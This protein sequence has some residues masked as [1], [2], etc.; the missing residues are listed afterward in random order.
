[1]KFFEQEHVFK[2]DWD[3]VTSAFWRKYPNSLQ[4]HVERVDMIQ[5][6]FD[7]INRNFMT[8]RLFTLYYH[9]PNWIETTTKIKPHGFAVEDGF[10]NLDKKRLELTTIN[11]T[12]SKIFQVAESCL[13]EVDPQNPNWTRYTSTS[14]FRVTG[15][16]IICSTLESMA[17]RQAEEKACNGIQVMHEKIK[18]IVEV[19]G[20]KS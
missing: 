5:F 7:T 2:N 1:M 11:Y 17:A 14:S 10:C 9:L 15:L 12:L 20:C 8:K 3:T 13:Y 19:A 18:N 4:P 6:D 16:G